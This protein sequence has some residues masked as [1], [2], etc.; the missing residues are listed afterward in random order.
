MG[1]TD[2][3]LYTNNNVTSVDLPKIAGI[4]PVASFRLKDTRLKKESW[5]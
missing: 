2:T 1:K 4:S 3:K 5:L